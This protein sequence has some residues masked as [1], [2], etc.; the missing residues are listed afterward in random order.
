MSPGGIACEHNCLSIQTA[1]AEMAAVASQNT[2]VKDPVYHVVLS[3]PSGEAPTDDQAFACGRH[4]IGAVG[5]ADHQYLFSVHRDT[6]HVHLHIAVNRVHPETLRA[7]YPDRDFFRLDRAMRELELQYGW[8]HDKGP[9]AVFERGGKKVIDWSSRAPDTKGK[10]PTRAAD[11]ERHTDAESLF[12]YVRGQ[13]KTAVLAYLKGDDVTWQGLHE[14]M[15]RFGLELREKG[16]GLAIFDLS[17]DVEVPV[18]ASD[19]H[20]SMSKPR[21]VK[22]I[23]AFEL[24]VLDELSEVSTTTYDKYRPLKRDAAKREIARQARADAR[25]DLRERYAAYRRTFVYRRLD[26][27]EVKRRYAD[28]REATRQRRLEIKTTVRDAAARKALYSVLAFEAL[29]SR[30]RLRQEIAQER[31]AL[32]ADPTNRRMSFRQWVEAEAL[33]GDEAAISQLRGWAYADKRRAATLDFQAR[34]VVNGYAGLGGEDPVAVQLADGISCSVRRSGT[35]IYRNALG[36]DLLVDHGECVEVVTSADADAAWELARRLAKR[37]F[38]DH[39]RLI[40]VK[41][42]KAAERLTT[43]AG[44]GV[45]PGPGSGGPPSRRRRRMA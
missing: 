31:N 22:R 13:P 38:G 12:T 44:D 34:A 32:R 19:M 6:A 37:K 27:N 41:R 28:L 17:G 23:G 14:V 3:W 11:M 36:Q 7:V 43:V 45:Q 29:R 33:K 8:R 16:Q 30:E 5:M 42:T 35:V 10:K 15:R 20:E 39:A 25:R 9:Y 40:D 21:L 18:K 24:P 4:A 1:A 2:R 26:A